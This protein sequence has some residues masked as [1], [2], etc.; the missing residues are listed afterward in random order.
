VSGLAIGVDERAESFRF[1][2]DDSHHKRQAE[3]AGADKGSRRASHAN[4]YGQRIL[5][6]TRV[7]GLAAK[8]RAVLAGPFDVRV[9]SDGK[10][11]IE[12]FNEKLVVVFESETKERVGFYERAAGRHDLSAAMRDQV[13][14]R[15][16]LEDGY[17]IGGTENG[18][19]AGESD[20][21]GAGGSDGQD[22]SRGRIDELGPVMFSDTENI[23]TNFVG[24]FNFFQK[25]LHA[26][27]GGA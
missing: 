3:H 24:E 19:G 27:L 9:R 13:E 25:M 21:F 20:C 16:F 23:E 5:Q 2:A 8:R 1:T 17:R 4:P 6:R 18:D 15:E 7:D 14:R 12:F 11:Q 26:R 10:E 22:Y